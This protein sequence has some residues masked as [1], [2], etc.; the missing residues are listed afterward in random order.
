MAY[1]FES[2][3]WRTFRELFEQILRTIKAPRVCEN[4][5]N[6]LRFDSHGHFENQ[7]SNQIHIFQYDFKNLKIVPK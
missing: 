6:E 2:N 5:L 4:I 3:K 7:I 1:H